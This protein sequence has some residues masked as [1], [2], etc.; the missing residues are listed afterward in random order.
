MVK[1]IFGNTNSC[2]NL[3]QKVFN[4]STC[5]FKQLNDQHLH[6]NTPISFERG[7]KT[8]SHCKHIPLQ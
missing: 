8:A 3:G 7:P 5:N 1:I 2:K 4:E 6:G